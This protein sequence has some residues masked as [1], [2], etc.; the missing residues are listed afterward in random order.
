[1]A[2]YEG[3]G[4]GRREEMIVRVERRSP[5]VDAPGLKADM[6]RALHKDLGVRVNVEIAEKGE[7]AEHTRMGREGKVRRL[8]DLRQ[9][10]TKPASRLIT[11]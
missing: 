7:L 1:V 11:A 4:L 9:T 8:L 3:E 6:E 2:Y 10:G 5:D